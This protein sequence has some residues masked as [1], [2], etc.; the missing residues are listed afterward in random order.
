MKTRNIDQALKVVPDTQVLIN[1][2]SRR[3]RQLNAGS[4][5]LVDVEPGN[6]FGLADIALLEISEGKVIRSAEEEE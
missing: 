2:V 5:P 3:V 4:R 6:G 1:M